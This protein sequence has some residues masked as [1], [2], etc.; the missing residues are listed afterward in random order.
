MKKSIKLV[1]VAL[2]SLM[3]ASAFSIT[4]SALP[5]PTKEECEAVGEQKIYFEF[6]DGTW[7]DWSNLKIN[8]LN[9]TLPVYCNPYAM[10]ST[11]RCPSTTTQRLTTRARR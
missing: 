1:S 7:G 9:N 2:A 6:P 3:A 11:A 4:A 8:K 5:R 10:T